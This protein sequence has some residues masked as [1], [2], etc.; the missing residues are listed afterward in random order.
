MPILGLVQLKYL[1]YCTLLS[2]TVAEEME[3]GSRYVKYSK[4]VSHLKDLWGDFSSSPKN[5]LFDEALEE[6]E[7]EGL[8]LFGFEDSDTVYVGELRGRKFF[9]FEL[10]SPLVDKAVEKVMTQIK[11]YGKHK[12]T[13]AKS[14]AKYLHKEFQ[15]LLD[16]GVENWQPQKFTE[17]HGILYELY[18]GGEQYIIRNKVEYYQTNNMLKAFDRTTLFSIMVEAVLNYHDYRNGLP[19]LVNVAFVKDEVLAKLTRPDGSKEYMREEL[20][21]S[22]D[23]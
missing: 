11:E 15:D 3:D 14:R 4:D 9:P 7:S 2:D 17:L 19:T 10:E 20:T 21:E 23:F 22:E 16:D 13:L 12:S 8:I 6:L 18:T 5:N 1:L